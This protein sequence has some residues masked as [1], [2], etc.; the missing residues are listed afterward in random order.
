[1]IT[2]AFSSLAGLASVNCDAFIAIS[3]ALC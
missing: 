2:V 3:F 1:M